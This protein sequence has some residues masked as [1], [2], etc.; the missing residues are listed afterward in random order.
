MQCSVI[1]TVT[2]IAKSLTAPIVHCNEVQCRDNTL[3]E[4]LAT[5]QTAIWAS[6]SVNL[7]TYCHSN[8]ILVGE[9]LS[10]ISNQFL[11]SCLRLSVKIL[12]IF[13]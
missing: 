11:L 6:L 13:L 1:C 5:R 8:S 9:S 2:S 4:L 3:K 10:K 12:Y 7:L